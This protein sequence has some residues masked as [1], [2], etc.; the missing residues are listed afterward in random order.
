MASC[1]QNSWQELLNLQ[2]LLCIVLHGWLRVRIRITWS[3]RW[4]CLQSMVILFVVTHVWGGEFCYHCWI[5]WQNFKT[6]ILSW[7]VFCWQTKCESDGKLHAELLTRTLDVAWCLVL[8]YF[9]LCSP[10]GFVCGQRTYAGIFVKIR[11][12]KSC[13]VYSWTWPNCIAYE[14]ELFLCWYSKTNRD[15]P[16]L[17]TVALLGRVNGRLGYIIPF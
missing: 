11:Y 8:L 16:D 2:F 10:E 6:L 12:P 17:S 7:A 1:M 14:V 5:W 3:L 13:I 9:V 15:T 4:C